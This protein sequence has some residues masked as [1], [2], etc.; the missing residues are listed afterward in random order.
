MSDPTNADALLKE[1][2]RRLSRIGAGPDNLEIVA[3]KLVDERPGCLE[4]RS[5]QFVAN[6]MS[7]EICAIRELIDQAEAAGQRMGPTLVRSAA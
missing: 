3:N 4:W 5:I 6:M 1:I 7:D 2:E